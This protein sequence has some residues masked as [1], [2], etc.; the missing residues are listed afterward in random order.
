MADQIAMTDGA[1][2]LGRARLWVVIVAAVALLI[3]VASAPAAVRASC[4]P[5][6]AHQVGVWFDGTQG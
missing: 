4:D 6:R 2:G 1:S 3:P 5:G